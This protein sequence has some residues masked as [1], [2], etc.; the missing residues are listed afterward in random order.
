MRSRSIIAA[1]PVLLVGAFASFLLLQRG[2]AAAPAHPGQQLADLYCAGCH[3]LPSPDHLPR[4]TWPEVLDWMGH[5]LGLRNPE[6]KLASVVDTLLV[7]SRP[8]ISAEDFASIRQYY[9]SLSRAG[10]LRPE[11]KPKLKEGIPWLQPE[12]RSFFP[13]PNAIITMVEIDEVNQRLFVGDGRRNTLEVFD[14]VGNP[15]ASATF[16][17]QPVGV[18]VHE[19]GFYLTL[20]GDLMRDQNNGQVHNLRLERGAVVGEPIIENYPRTADATFGDLTGN[21]L[22]DV[23]I[24]GFGDFG[25]GRFAWLENRG[26]GSYREHVL[27]DHA[28]ALKA[29]IHDFDGDGRPDIL[30]LVAQEHQELIVFLNRGGGRFERVQLVKKFAAFGFQSFEIAD[31]NGNGRMDILLVN[32]NNME[33][34]DA[35]LRDYHGLRIYLNEGDLQFRE[36]YFYPMYGAIGARVADFSGNGRPDIAAVAFFPDWEAEQPEG[37]VLLEQTGPLRFTPRTHPAAR[38]GRWMRIAA[39]DFDGNGAIDLVLGGAVLPHGIPRHLAGEFVQRF[40][41]VPPVLVLRNL[42][43]AR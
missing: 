33:I 16:D 17:T 29:E 26:D 12:E 34:P 11:R 43:A 24:S 28:G 14:R 37:F 1:V 40:H 27:L 25:R 5:Y 4:E 22:D 35:P 41:L 30:T 42:G 7:P 18:T 23:V 21:G 19:D 2:S 36:A 10:P 20:I 32:G 13:F 15:L 39:G 9:L 8:L 6:A 38:G 3:E 31:F